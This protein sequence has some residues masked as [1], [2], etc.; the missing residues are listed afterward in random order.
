MRILAHLRR[1]LWALFLPATFHTTPSVQC[2]ALSDKFYNDYLEAQS[3]LRGG[4]GVRVLHA[5]NQLEN[6]SRLPCCYPADIENEKYSLCSINYESSEDLPTLP[7]SSAEDSETIGLGNRPADSDASSVSLQVEAS[8]TIFQNANARPSTGASITS[9]GPITS[10]SAGE[11]NLETTISFQR[12]EFESKSNLL[13]GEFFDIRSYRHTGHPT[14]TRTTGELIKLEMNFEQLAK[15]GSAFVSGYLHLSY[16]ASWDIAVIT[17]SHTASI[18]TW[19]TSTA[20]GI[21]NPSPFPYGPEAGVKY[22][23]RGEFERGISQISEI[24]HRVAEAVAITEVAPNLTVESPAYSGSVQKAALQGQFL[25]TAIYNSATATWDGRWGPYDKVAGTLPFK[26]TVRGVD[27]PY[28]RFI[29]ENWL[30]S[31][32]FSGGNEANVV[33]EFAEIGPVGIFFQAPFWNFDQFKSSNS[34]L[35]LNTLAEE[36]GLPIRMNDVNTLLITARDA[37]TVVVPAVT[38][39]VTKTVTHTNTHIPLFGRMT[40]TKKGTSAERNPHTNSRFLIWLPWVIA[41]WVVFFVC[42]FALA[43]HNLCDFIE[44]QRRRLFRLFRL[45]P[46]PAPNSSFWNILRQPTV[47]KVSGSQIVDP[48]MLQSTRYRESKESFHSVD[49][50]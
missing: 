37:A 3:L 28:T 48:A 31:Q 11:G 18:G 10:L 16:D 43:W 49:L 2:L 39:V 9:P 35:P 46:E 21:V 6:R 44:R 27:G 17:G 12:S 50:D 14:P 23:V 25:G 47:R 30:V 38:E 26:A 5:L 24:Y 7:T 22:W 33:K 34:R 42:S 45:D 15:A 36:T 1:S 40:A 29:S 32:P 4:V 19:T 41:F 13:G 20:Y 8:T